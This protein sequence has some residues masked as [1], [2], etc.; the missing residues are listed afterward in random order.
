VLRH[1]AAVHLLDAGEGID[2]ARDHLG[3][4]S[5]E[6]TLVYARVSNERR[7]RALRRL[8]RSR[9]FPVPT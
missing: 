8:E 3:H 6:S 5:I 1:S 9:D 4:R 2:F 7:R